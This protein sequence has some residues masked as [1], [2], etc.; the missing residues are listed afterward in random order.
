[1]LRVWSFA[2]APPTAFMAHVQ[3]L[4]VTD[5]PGWY[6]IIINNKGHPLFA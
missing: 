2:L 3:T 1:M 5:I 6:I 4:Q